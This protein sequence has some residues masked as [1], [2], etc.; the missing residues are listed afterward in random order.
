MIHAL[1]CITAFALMMLC[2][3][4]AHA[5]TETIAITVNDRAITQSDIQRRGDLIIATSGLQNTAE[6][7]KKLTPQIIQTL[8]DEELQLE[9]A[10][11][12]EIEISQDDVD[13]EFARI[14]A[15][16]NLPADK[17]KKTLSAR[18][19][20]VLSLERQFKA[21]VAWARIFTQSLR[22]N[23]R[24][25]EGDITDYINRVSA[26][27]GKTEYLISEI[28][29]PVE[30]SQKEN[31]IRKLAQSI[32]RDIK[33]KRAPFPAV[34]QQ[35]SKAAGAQNG[36]LK[37]WVLPEHLEDLLA[38]HILTLPV[39]GVSSPIRAIEGYYILRLNKKRIITADTIPDRDTARRIIAAERAD[40][41]SQNA[42]NGLR[43][44]AYID[45]RI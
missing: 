41:V 19:A 5:V 38:Q 39:G 10:E 22:N 37:G 40:R 45:V 23:V 44:R 35:L 9:E 14:A 11:R 3:L 13:T 17:F 15:Q 6:S 8:I 33:N 16:N 27:T 25:S 28:F 31:E 29:L 32:V 24:I 42:L 21:R 30:E 1:R 34:A 2:A 20:S 43:S 12:L 36:G 26:Q 4:N 18:G 7:R